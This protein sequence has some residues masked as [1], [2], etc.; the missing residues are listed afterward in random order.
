MGWTLAAAL[1]M[2]AA[3]PPAPAADP[4]LLAPPVDV[5]RESL[6]QV[7]VRVAAPVTTTDPQ[8]VGVSLGIGRAGTYRT[9][10]RY[11]P[12]ESDFFGFVHATMGWR[13][14]HGDRWTVAL[15]L[16]HTRVWAASRLYRAD[17]FQLEGHDRRQLSLGTLSAV[18]S[19]RR[20]FGLVD[21][22]EIGA[23]QMRIRRLVAGRVGHE[24]LNPDLVW[25]LDSAAPVGMV[26]ARLARPLRWGFTG[27]ARVRLIGAGRSR[28]GTVPFAHVTAE[29]EVM[30]RLFRSSR[31][32]QGNIGLTGVHASSSRAATYYQNGLGVALK[33]AF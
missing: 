15:D 18:S 22:V 9:G 19:G 7:A 5:E 1:T 20:F 32:G 29:W 3:V 2:L 21:G 31:L 14:A 12:A 26:G 23:G 24:L 25:I 16:E 28:G 13:L 33:I 27:H 10:I 11:Q 4:A 6:W 17:G 30:R 8:H